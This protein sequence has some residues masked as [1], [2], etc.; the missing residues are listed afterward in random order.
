MKLATC[1]AAMAITF[2]AWK[3]WRPI[4]YICRI[5]MEPLA[6]DCVLCGEQYNMREVPGMGSTVCLPA[7][8]QEEEEC[9]FAARVGPDAVMISFQRDIARTHLPPF[10]PDNSWRGWVDGYVST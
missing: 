8:L 1:S 6:I 3:T 7:P 9:E 2:H 10:V 4:L 5:K